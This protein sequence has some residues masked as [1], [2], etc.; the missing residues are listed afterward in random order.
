MSS[1][2]HTTVLLEETVTALCPRDGGRYI[3][4]TLG[5]AGHSERLLQRSEPG[6]QLLALDQDETAL[7]HAEDK[8]RPYGDRVQLVHANFRRIR[9]VVRE[10]EFGPVD[11][12]MFDL[13]VSS[14]Q[15]DEA[16]RGFSYRFDAPLDM[17]MDQTQP[18][19]ARDMVNGL[20][21]AELIR[22]FTRYGEEKF[23]KSIARRIVHRRA[24]APIETTGEL[25]EL[26][27]E[28]IPAPARRTGPHPA[29]RVF[30]A[31]R[32]AVNDE[33]GALEEALDGAFEV[34][35]PGGRLAVITFH[36]LEDRIVKHQFQQWARGCTCPPDFPVC[37]CG[38][39]PQATIVTR[40]PIVP[41]AAEEIENPRSRSAK[42]RVVEK[43]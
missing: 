7:R 34:L 17:R 11:G 31:L 36:S 35:K 3:D 43:R 19:T 30:Q 21:E 32:I 8:L 38:N 9:E 29:R 15:F 24:V 25:A 39:V 22:I 26:I 40:K 18:T 33:L 14:P 2:V 37:Q 23:S 10:L 12:V 41:S 13:G 16:D 4:C 1:F 20:D 6:G 27:K 42:L 28:A 5:G